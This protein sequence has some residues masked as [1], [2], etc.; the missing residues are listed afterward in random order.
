LPVPSNWSDL[1]E[2]FSKSGKVVRVLLLARDGTQTGRAIVSFD[3]PEDAQKALSFSGTDF[4]GNKIS[5]FPCKPRNNGP[6]RDRNDEDN[7]D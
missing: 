3:G 1:K 5:V 4:K 7:L 6:R 2:V